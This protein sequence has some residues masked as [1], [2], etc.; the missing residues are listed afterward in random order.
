MWCWI[1][2]YQV[3]GSGSAS[4]Q[5]WWPVPICSST[6]S[7]CRHCTCRTLHVAPVWYMSPVSK[8]WTCIGDM[9]T[10]YIEFYKLHVSAACIMNCGT[11]CF[12]HVAFYSTYCFLHVEFYMQSVTCRQCGLGIYNLIN[13]FLS[14]E[15]LTNSWGN[16]KFVGFLKMCPDSLIDFN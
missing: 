6:L 15:D 12:W 4:P 10:I 2:W 7:A 3:C 16:A 9:Y 11:C 13:Y 5:F 1:R 14:L 8:S